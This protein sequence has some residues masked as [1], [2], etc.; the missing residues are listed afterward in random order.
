MDI[1][2]YKQERAKREKE[3][4]A[5]YT[6]YY[7]QTILPRKAK[8]WLTSTQAF[9]QRTYQDYEKRQEHYTTPQMVQSYKEQNQ[10]EKEALLGSFDLAKKYA[11]QIEDA[12]SR[13]S[14]LDTIDNMRLYLSGFSS[15]LDDETA[16]WE[17]FPDEKAY[18]AWKD[19]Q[20]QLAY[21]QSLTEQEDF[22]EHA[23][24][25]VEQG[26][27]TGDQQYKYINR[28][29]QTLMSYDLTGPHKYAHWNY[30]TDEERSIYNYLYSK[31]GK[32][33]RNAISRLLKKL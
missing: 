24:H 30:L 32:K 28:D 2:V 13:Q 9:M 21:F 10:T 22:E 31:S 33:R 8:E 17:Q 18:T 14:Y 3:K 20:D 23:N 6:A 11:D 1:E 27:W 25:I 12:A 16:Y 26:E 19:Q 4:A 5:Q 15:Y 29:P 7:E